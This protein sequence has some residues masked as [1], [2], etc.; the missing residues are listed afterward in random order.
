M[1]IIHSSTRY[2]KMNNDDDVYENLNYISILDIIL[3]ELS[4]L[5]SSNYEYQNF[6]L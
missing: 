1:D 2:K 5:Y 4:K 6:K 3:S